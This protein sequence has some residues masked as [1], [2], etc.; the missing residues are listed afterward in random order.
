L[1]TA[2]YFKKV[3][4]NDPNFPSKD[5]VLYNLAYYS[6]KAAKNVR[7][8]ARI[9][10]SALVINW[11]DSLRLSES[12]ALIKRSINAYNIIVGYYPDS[13]FNSEALYRLGTLYFDLALDA[14]KPM[15]YYKKALSYFD[16][17]AHRSGDSLQNYAIFQRGWTYFVSGDFN[18]AI[19]DFTSILEFV[20]QDS[21]SEQKTY[22]EEDAVENIAFSL[23]EFDG[24][25]FN[26]YSDAANKLKDIFSNFVSQD[27]AKRI[28]LDAIKLKLKY[29]APMQAIDLYNAYM[30]LYPL[31]IDHPVYIDSIVTIYRK[32]PD[33]TRNH[34]DPKELIVEQYI[35]LTK[36]YAVTS[37]WF[38]ANKE[39]ET[40]EN[41]ITIILNAYNFIEKRYYNNFVKKQSF[42]TYDKYK[43]LVDHY[44][45]LANV[46]GKI[47]K[48]KEKTIRQN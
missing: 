41:K 27:Y 44:F 28:I 9:R 11:P 35:R 33:R 17:L 12:S 45:A 7:D 40:I 37:D 14:K 25:D 32:Y 19:A 3:L 15:E 26:K 10:N 24:T 39:N 6:F 4:E 34:R 47:D 43:E 23:I 18:D 46:V 42:T 1:A 36:D 30:Q 21:L 8:V 48:D 22:F 20:T 2:N 16:K 31:D 5:Q 13:Q 38:N 29:Y